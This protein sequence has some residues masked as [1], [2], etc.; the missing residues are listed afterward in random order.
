GHVYVSD[1]SNRRVVAM[2]RKGGFLREIKTGTQPV[3]VALNQK[4]VLYISDIYNG[5]VAIF[6]RQSKKI[7]S[8]GKGI[9]EFKQ[10]VA[11]SIC[12]ESQNIAIADTEAGE[13]RV[14][15]A[16]GKDKAR[17]KVG[18]KPIGVICN[19]DETLW[20][21]D[22][23][24]S[25]IRVIA[26]DGTLREVVSSFGDKADELV[27]PG[28]IIRDI[29]GKLFVVDTFQARLSLFNTEGLFIQHLIGD[30]PMA[31][32]LPIDVATDTAGRIFVSSKGL[33]RIIIFEQIGAVPFDC[34]GDTDCDGMPDIFE[35]TWG[36]DINDASDAYGDADNDGLVNVDEATHGTDPT[37][38]DSDGD[39]VLDGKE[40]DLG[41]D[42]TN[43][44]DNRPVAIGPDAQYSS[45]TLLFL[46]GSSSTDPNGD[47]LTYQWTFKTG[48]EEP[49]LFDENTQIAKVALHKNGAYSFELTVNDGKATSPAITAWIHI[50]INNTISDAGTTL[51]GVVGEAVY[52]NA[53]SSRDPN[54]EPLYYSWTQTD[55]PIVNLLQS[56][57]ANSGFVPPQAGIYSFELSTWSDGNHGELAYIHIIV[58]AADDHPPIAHTNRLIFGRVGE[59]ITMDGSRSHDKDGDEL[60]FQWTKISGPPSPTEGEDTSFLTLTPNTAQVFQYE[61]VVMDENHTSLP[62][63]V[64]VVVRDDINQPPTAEAG[65]DIITDLYE[66]VDLD[67]SNSFDPDFQTIT[68]NW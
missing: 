66:R 57:S 9:G 34:V 17:H 32:P 20:V 42:P 19:G 39:G 40:I 45:P 47:E 8:L 28:G 30:N 35:T 26:A 52:L 25:E 18:G 29:T 24:S 49:H 55:G 56:T 58:T 48:P 46:D 41:Q 50:G 37:N 2:T 15:T 23:Q 1:P 63:S 31:L 68:C 64:Y 33:G 61:L 54:G 60:S 43:P 12:P 36:F 67:C 62:A 6:N 51:H 5:E 22:T 7:G 11:L 59:T 16:K 44:D 38:P 3:G 65:P 21:S 27:R 14:F 53:L 13:I 4:G 10:P